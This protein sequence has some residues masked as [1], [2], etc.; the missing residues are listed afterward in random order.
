MR[1]ATLLAKAALALVLPFILAHCASLLSERLPLKYDEQSVGGPNSSA[2]LQLYLPPGNGPFAA[3]LVMHSCSG[4]SDNHPVLGGSPGQLGLRRGDRRQFRAT[5]STQRLRERRLHPDFRAC[6]GRPQ[7]RDLSAHLAQH[8]GRPDRDH[9]LL[10]RWL[11]DPLCRDRRTHSCRPRRPPVSSG[12]RLL[13]P[14]LGQDDRG[15]VCH[16]RADPDR[17]E[18]HLELRPTSASSRL[19]REPSKPIRPPSR[20]IPVRCTS[21]DLG[22]LPMLSSSGHMIGGNPE[23]AADSFAMTKAFLDARLKAK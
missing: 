1:Y 9:W 12:S 6:A 21:F 23:A 11:V 13:P 19:R 20:S 18:R 16:G 14:M 8:P 7:R 3:V 5:Q 4:I 10:S 22:G 2:P 17:Q 15:A